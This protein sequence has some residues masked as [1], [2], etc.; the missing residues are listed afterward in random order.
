V[1]G[2]PALARL[3]ADYTVDASGDGYRVL[4]RRDATSAAMATTAVP[5]GADR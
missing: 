2:F 5:G 1:D 3:L 4:A